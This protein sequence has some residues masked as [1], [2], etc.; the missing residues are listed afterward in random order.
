MWSLTLPGKDRLLLA[1]GSP[2]GS[3]ET[4]TGQGPAYAGSTV[5]KEGAMDKP[6]QGY[7][8]SD[9]PLRIL[10][11]ALH[12]STSDPS[13]TD[14]GVVRLVLNTDAARDLRIDLNQ[15]IGAQS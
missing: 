3:M 1:S 4:L 13:G 10:D 7:I 12:K 8:R 15:F 6:I 9:M 2:R 14:D 5:P 11:T